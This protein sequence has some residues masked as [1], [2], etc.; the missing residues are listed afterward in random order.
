MNPLR[1]LT[2]TSGM[3]GARYKLENPLHG[4]SYLIRFSSRYYLKKYQDV[5]NAGVDP[6]KHYQ[7]HG[8]KE[9]RNPSPL[10]STKFYISQ[11]N[12]I[13]DAHRD[14]LTHYLR[15]GRKEGAR[16]HPLFNDVKINKL[17]VGI[18]TVAHNCSDISMLT[19]QSVAHAKTDITVTYVLIDGGSKESEKQKLRDFCANFKRSKLTI[20]FIDLQQ[21][22]GYSGSNNIGISKAL[23]NGC[24]HVCL[25]NPDVV[26]TDYWLERMISYGEPFVSPVSN[27]VGNEQTVPYDYQVERSPSCFGTVNEFARKW[28]ASFEETNESTDFVG[29][30]CALL[31]R[32]VV[33]AVGLLDERFFPGG[34]ED[35]DYC[36]RARQIGIEPSVARHVYLHH[37][38]SSSF[39]NLPMAERLMHV[40]VNRKRFEEK[41][42][43]FL[44]D[45]KPTIFRS[46][47]DDFRRARP[48]VSSE[49]H[50]FRDRIFE[51]HQNACKELTAAL[52]NDSLS[53]RTL[54]DE[55]GQEIARVQHALASAEAQ[56]DELVG[57]IQ[58][59]DETYNVPTRLISPNLTGS[60]TCQTPI[61]LKPVLKGDFANRDEQVYAD[62]FY[63][64]ASELVLRGAPNFWA[65]SLLLPAIARLAEFMIERP[66]IVLANGA[67]PIGAD[68]RDGYL[69]R[70]LA[71][72][73]IMENRTR[74][75]LKISPNSSEAYRI[76]FYGKGMAV[77]DLCSDDP[78]YTA[79]L[80]GVMKFGRLIYIHSVLSL[81]D[82]RVR[83]ALA[84]ANG[85]KIIDMHGAVPEEFVMQDDRINSVTFGSYESEIV[86]DADWIVCVS[87]EM[88]R[89]LVGKHG[90]SM[91]KFIL[92]PIFPRKSKVYST[93]P[94]EGRPRVIYAG[95]TQ[96]WQKIP[97][98]AQAIA[99]MRDQIDYIVFSPNPERIRH[100][101]SEVGL[102]DFEV[103]RYVRSAS[104]AE[105][106]QAYGSAHYGL[107]LRADSIVNRVSCPTKLI[108]YLAFG[109]VPIFESASIGD[110]LTLG[111]QFL[112]VHD[113][114]KGKLPSEAERR[115]MANRNFKVVQDLARQSEF[116]LAQIKKLVNEN[117]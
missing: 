96:V 36:I 8:W 57:I 19:V 41:H 92:C 21:N 28:A 31:K 32:E 77:I 10:F 29:F 87:D 104:H 46:A 25:L 110:F 33:D 70:M 9:G 88:R 80:S 39:S 103:Q 97:E 42:G 85:V 86:R 44:I 12:F 68:E 50:K 14:P 95:G 116:G 27:A 45:W 63:L 30:F 79:L 34:Y 90:V 7:K 60:V 84:N 15:E 48:D 43:T 93:P 117:L 115:K 5:K 111:T 61:Q 100:A 40:D 91:N 106:Q 26:V 107:L 73:R 98:M 35:N 78:V 3:S 55:K 81:G 99:A 52:K 58:S 51:G 82:S 69:Q 22:L 24:T 62:L 38:G 108:E 114:V 113:V 20:Q 71:I 112:S 65:M 11:R 105:V 66:I 1:L 49:M 67:D 89:Y 16:P 53:I 4:E 83:D 75:Y 54:L 72:D 56:R 18:V 102:S 13:P 76:T 59:L 64:L 2:L 74:L 47:I 23:A 37:W 6:W 109:I 101:L 94:E 17:H